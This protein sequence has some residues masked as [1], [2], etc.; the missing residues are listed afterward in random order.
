MNKGHKIW[1]IPAGHIP[2]RSGDEEPA[3]TSRDEVCF[4]NLGDK[5]ANIQISIYYVDKEPIGPYQLTVD[6]RR[7]RHVRFNDLIDPEAIPLETDF[8]SLIISDIPLI[9]QFNRFYADGKAIS[10]STAM[11][12]PIA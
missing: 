6:A 11:A 12:F 7:T 8:A 9:V 5:S 3:F 2:N 4:L 1:A 10:Q